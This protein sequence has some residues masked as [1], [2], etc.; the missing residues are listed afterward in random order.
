MRLPILRF[1]LACAAVFSPAVAFAN[2]AATDIAKPAVPEA[3][4]PGAQ[5]AGIEVQPAKIALAGKYEGAQVVITARLADG[6]TAD[7]TRLAGY[8]LSG[9]CADVTKTGRVNA[10]TNG[11][12][13]LAIEIAG[14]K[15]VVPVEV[16]GVAE[17][18]PVDFI[19]DV[20]PVMTRLGCNAGTCHGAKDGKFGFKLSLRGYD[21][22][23]DVRSLKDDL[24][25][26]RLNVASPEDSLMLLKATAG[27]PHEGGQRTKLGEKYYEILRAWIADGA[28]LDLAAVRVVKIEVSPRDPVVQQIG[29]R[30]QV[31]VVAT[32]SDGKTRDV[33]AEAFVESGN[34]DVAK[35]DGG[36]LIETLR[37]GEAPL[38]ARYE[39]SYA[40][41][42]LT[43]MG[44]RTG[45][46]WQQ[47]ET[48]G[49]IDELVAAKWQRMKIA[50]SGLCS[51]ADFLRRVSLDLAGLPPTADEV[52][53]FLADARPVRE[54]RGAV[55]EKLLASPE[56]IEHSANKWADLLQVNSKFLGGEGA[57]LFREW[58]RKEM[59]AKTPYDQ[60]VR[61]ILT[62]SGSNKDNPAASY[63]KILRDPAEAMEN[64][65]HLFLATRFNCNKCHDHPFERWTQDQYYHTSAFFSQVAFAA[66][67]AAGGAKLEGTAV[68]KARPLYE[69]VS[70]AKDGEVTHLRTNK[71]AAPEFPFPAQAEQKGSRREQLAAWMTSPDN[72][73]FATSYV[74]R[75]WGYLTGAG[76]IE[77]L[78]DIRAGNPPTNPEL[79]DYLTKEFVA[80]GFDA[81]HVLRLICQSRT[82]QL[83]IATN[84]WNA[85]D[86]INYSHALARRLPAEVLY[87]SVLKVV[88][89]APRL[90]GGLRAGQLPDSATD[91]PS[92]FLANL[93][94]PARE[95][96]CECERSSDLR[97]GSIMALLG[98]PAVSE[99]IGDAGNELAKLTAAQPDD[100]KLVDELFTRVLSRPASE[101][102]IGKVLE[103]WS[104]IDADNAALLA[105]LDAKEK[106]QAPLIAKAEADRVAAIAAAKAELA[107]YEAEIATKTGEAEK[108]RVADITAADAA[109]KDYEAKNLAA[110]QTAFEN[111]AP[112]ART[113]TGWTPLDIVEARAT[114]GITLTKQ[115]DGSYLASGARPSTTDY[116]VKADVKL[117]GITGIGIEALPSGEEANFGPGRFPTDG[118]FVLG[119]IAL[120]VGEFGTGATPADVKFTGAVADF[121]QVNFEVQKAIDGKKGDE[122]NGWAVSGGFGVPHFAAL[123]L[124]KPIG[125]AEK[126]VRLR[127]E[128]NQP[129][130]GGFAIARFRL[131]VTTGAAPVQVGYPQPV[132]DALKKIPAA[133]TDADKAALTAYW[134]AYDPELS[135]RRLT[136][137]KSQLPPPTDP[138]LVQRRTDIATAELPITLDAKLVRL[139]QDAEQSKAQLANRR[140]TGVQDLAWALINNPAFLF[141]H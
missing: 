103:S 76:I 71:V 131:W 2:P 40:A 90:P 39:G 133:R 132:I 54:K 66:D 8:Q 25:G 104:G 9:D 136:L 56:F 92:G 82:Y 12:A 65:T 95:S 137:A 24:A 10:R 112:V 49:R 101:Q 16:T 111:S 107:R 118:N 83:G 81:R 72:R 106:E 48:W 114:G 11:T 102:E 46:V 139:R 89:S 113:F 5:I 59:E 130:K 22:I 13:S 138:G 75:L 42:T 123:T 15:A 41:T 105:Q 126:G 52:R 88:G 14:Q 100:R 67:P 116:T 70:D 57:R 30:Q 97:L 62:A 21:P 129:R 55:I 29:A 58:I 7:V 79:L 63:W 4:P 28:K 50:P 141:N 99:A 44:D 32:F 34:G 38:L 93:G 64:T 96:S 134:N 68:E 31:R 33:T 45:F 128:M 36:G 125:D 85:D 77:P 1:L 119:E 74:N 108:K 127:F 94:R 117:A 91:L 47:P 6:A 80:H 120:K 84:Q 121:N 78:D 51:D 98:G 73:Y 3:L 86:R 27:V 135:K 69:I 18:Q 19:R 61:K 35:T 43:V 124:E 23:F 109:V 26:R 110:A 140:L 87:D 17:I 122:N 53:A 115:P 37:R 20:N 60:F